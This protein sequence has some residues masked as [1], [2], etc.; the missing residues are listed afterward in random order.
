M[1]E[2]RGGDAEEVEERAGDNSFESV[3]DTWKRGGGLGW[4]GVR[5]DE[6]GWVL[7]TPISHPDIPDCAAIGRVPQ[8]LLRRIFR[9]TPVQKIT[10]N[11]HFLFIQLLLSLR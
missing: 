6:R 2:H 3:A 1:G 7:Y 9:K 4:D 11:L 5:W 10:L 8:S